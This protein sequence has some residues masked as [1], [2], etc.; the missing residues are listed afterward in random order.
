MRKV[1]K[2]IIW[3][4]RYIDIV[5]LLLF[6][7]PEFRRLG[8]NEKEMILRAMYD[9]DYWPEEKELKKHKNLI[10]KLAILNVVITFILF[11]VLLNFLLM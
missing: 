9:L 6:L 8:K 4:V 7:I 11:L 2:K 3:K 5:Y 10:L 1:L